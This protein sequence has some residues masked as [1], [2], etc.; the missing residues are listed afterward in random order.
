MVEANR[1]GMNSVGFELNPFASLVCKVKL[2]SKSVSLDEFIESIEDY[3]VF[4]ENAGRRSTSIDDDGNHNAAAEP[5]SLLPRGSKA[6][7]PSSRLPSR[8]R[9]SLPSTT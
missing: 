3:E 9:S 6:E 1:L 4:I 7:F 8:G 5:R 2:N